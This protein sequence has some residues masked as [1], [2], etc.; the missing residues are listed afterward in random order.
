MN[1][2]EIILDNG[3]YAF[4]NSQ[5]TQNAQ[6]I[7]HFINRDGE[8]AGHTFV[9]LQAQVLQKLIKKAN[10]L[11]AYIEDK[12]QLAT[13]THD[14]DASMRLYQTREEAIAYHKAQGAIYVTDTPYMTAIFKHDTNLAAYVATEQGDV[15]PVAFE[16]FVC[17]KAF[18]SL[19]NTIESYEALV[20][21]KQ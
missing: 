12:Q 14:I 1:V 15:I 6:N 3:K 13:F 9:G 21:P 20:F 7:V 17:A 5:D 4:Q 10:L 18:I 8:G 2:N 16:P 19:L 11:K